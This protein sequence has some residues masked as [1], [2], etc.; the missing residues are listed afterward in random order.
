MMTSAT[1][2]TSDGLDRLTQPGYEVNWLWYD[3]IALPLF[4]HCFSTWHF[5][6]S[7]RSKLPYC[8]LCCVCC[9]LQG[10][11]ANCIYTVL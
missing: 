8:R 1:N 5:C 4:L 10:H 11:T 2:C 9:W 7:W 3:T 6:S